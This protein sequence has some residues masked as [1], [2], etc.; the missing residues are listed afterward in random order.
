MTKLSRIILYAVAFFFWLFFLFGAPTSISAQEQHGTVKVD[1]L[2]VYSG[3]SAHSDNVATLTRGTSVRIG[4]SV[5]NEEGRWCGISRVD[6][7]EKLGYV[8]VR[9][10]RSAERSQRGT[11][12]RR[13][14]F[15]HGTFPPSTPV[16][17]PKGLGDSSVRYPRNLQSRAAWRSV[18]RR[19]SR[20]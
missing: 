12:P 20:T 17:H 6:T 19:R 1:S 10:T 18:C 2:Q 11:I 16:A 4:F 14:S 13:Y 8:R 9:R 3:M 7:S 5:T 15:T